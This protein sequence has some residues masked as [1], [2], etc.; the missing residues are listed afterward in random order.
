LRCMPIVETVPPQSDDIQLTPYDP[1]NTI[2]HE[3]SGLGT[4][5]RTTPTYNGRVDNNR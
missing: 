3:S 5:R 2:S 1:K 4:I